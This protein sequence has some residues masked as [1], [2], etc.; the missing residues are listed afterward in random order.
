MHHF[1]SSDFDWVYI[2]RKQAPANVAQRGSATTLFDKSKADEAV[3]S[4]RPL[5]LRDMT[6]SKLAPMLLHQPPPVATSTLTSLTSLHLLPAPP[7][8]F[9]SSR[10]FVLSVASVT[11]LSALN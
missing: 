9:P 1:Q 2:M 10:A 3:E 6:V 8:S 7:I 5:A 4:P 11:A